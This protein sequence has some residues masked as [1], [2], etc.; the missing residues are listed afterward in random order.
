[1][2]VSAKARGKLARAEKKAKMALAQLPDWSRTAEELERLAVPLSPTIEQFES[3]FHELT[4]LQRSLAER[5]AAE[6]DAIR[7]LESL[8]QSLELQQAVP[9]EEVLARARERRDQ[10]WQMVKS[11]WLDKAPAGEDYDAF[12]IEFAPNGTLSSAFEESFAR[13]D[14]IA[15][16]LRREADRVAH[17][18]ES[19]AQL[20]RHRITRKALVDEVQSLNERQTSLDREWNALVGPLA[21]N[22]QSNTPA[23]LRAGCASAKRWSSSSQR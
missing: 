20:D 15:D 14:A 9:S 21:I 1:M 18:A 2:P 13:S 10:G 19:L 4:R 11:A 12:V 17:K 16:R 8:L 3:Q 22:S 23:E 5:V 7:Q 6:D